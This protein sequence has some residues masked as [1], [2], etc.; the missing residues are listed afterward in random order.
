MDREENPT[1]YVGMH[2]PKLEPGMHSY[3]AGRNATG[4]G[5]EAPS[6]TEQ[7]LGDQK[8]DRPQSNSEI[9]MRA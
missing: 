9:E 5:A 6:K 4:I 7:D 2:E 1:R 8:S 3:A